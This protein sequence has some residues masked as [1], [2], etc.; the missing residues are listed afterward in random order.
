MTPAPGK[1]ARRLVS[2]TD[3]FCE[4]T[5]NL[6]SP[7][8]F[9]KWAAIGCV[10]AAMERKVWSSTN[11]GDL[12]ANLYMI[13][14]GGPGSG[15]STVLQI[16]ERML[17]DLTDL[18]VSP[19]SVTTASLA[20]EMAQAKRHIIRHNEK[21]NF[22]EFNYL[23]AMASELG[24]FLPAYENS[25]MNML[26]KMYDGE[27]YSEK[28]RGIKDELK[29]PHPLL[30]LLGGTT[31]AYLASTLPPGAWDQGF[32]SR[33]I[34]VFSSEVVRKEVFGEDENT[35]ERKALY[36]DLVHD[37]KIIHSLV[38]PVRWEK[39]A[40]AA[41]SAWHIA[42]GPPAPHHPRLQWYNSRRTAH[43][44]KL[45][46]NFSVARG[47]DMVVTIDDYNQALAALLEAEEFMPD[48]FLMGSHT[49][50]SKAADE[51]H[52][53]IFKT[54]GKEGKPIADHRVVNFAREKV[55]AHVVTRI[56]DLL[57]RSEAIR[58]EFIDGRKYWRAQARRVGGY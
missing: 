6:T 26:T 43:V 12:F 46:M 57:E 30:T 16:V 44:L 8:I 50:D 36:A 15:K 51:I 55:P 27:Y 29:I 19:S 23:V 5:N 32:T 28:R 4:Y 35:A 38:G 56:I 1:G 20:D 40:M 34:L 54:Q 24:I 2:W 25:F 37:L 14:V 39:E 3:A 9:R 58:P 21:P 10:A 41:I 17:R 33:T 49:D 31:P 42:G 11:G 45:A 7:L 53:F 52:F 13:L 47:G 22:L 18:H 48:I